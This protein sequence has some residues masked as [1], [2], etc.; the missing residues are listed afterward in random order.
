VRAP[1]A[2]IGLLALLLQRVPG[3]PRRA[4]NA[5][6][7]VLTAAIVAGVRG[8]S[9]PFT[10]APPPNL[11][12]HAAE[13]PF[14]AAAALLHALFS[15]PELVVVALVLGGVAAAVPFALRRGLLWIAGLSGALL[16]GLV[17]GAPHASVVPLVAAAWITAVVL[18]LQERGWKPLIG[19][20][21]AARLRF[22]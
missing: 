17:V 18:A 9:L 14:T 6:I 1:L 16:A 8:T 15:R 4:A 7:G 5:C 19:A 22:E 21:G 20:V 13:S 11:A 3:T 12:L 10:A 2:M